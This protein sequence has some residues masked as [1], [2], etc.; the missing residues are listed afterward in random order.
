MVVCACCTRERPDAKIRVGL[1]TL[2]TLG[3]TTPKPFHGPLCDDCLIRV[4]R[5]GSV[6]QRWLLLQILR[7]EPERPVFQKPSA[8]GGGTRA[9][10][11]QSLG[12]RPWTHCRRP[13]SCGSRAYF[14]AND[15]STAPAESAI[16]SQN[17]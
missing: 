8:P 1:R 9:R 4:S 10:L 7:T 6:E 17:K 3:K 15:A 2:D 16:T 13:V 12:A 11:I 14:I 5:N